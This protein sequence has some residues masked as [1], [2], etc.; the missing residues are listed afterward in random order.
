MS[1][2]QGHRT[3]DVRP[4]N[5]PPMASIFTDF[6]EHFDDAGA[7]GHMGDLAIWRVCGEPRSGWRSDFDFGYFE[8][9]EDDIT[10]I[11]E[12]TDDGGGECVGDGEPR[13]RCCPRG[14]T[15]DAAGHC[16]PWCHIEH[17][18]PRDWRLCGLGFD[19]RG[20]RCLDGSAPTNDTPFGCVAASPIL[21]AKVCPAGWART[22]TPGAGE[23]CAPTPQQRH[24]RRGEQAGPDGVCRP[25]C[26][27]VAWP[28]PPCCAPGVEVDD[29]GACCPEG[30][31]LDGHKQC[32]P[33]DSRLTPQGECCPAGVE[34]DARGACCV[35]GARLDHNRMCCAPGAVVDGEGVCCP[36]GARLDS[37][38]QCCPIDAVTDKRGRCCPVGAHVN[39]QTGNCTRP[40]PPLTPIPT[41][42]CGPNE[43]GIAGSCCGRD[44]VYS[45][46]EGRL[47]CCPHPLDAHG[48]CE[49][50]RPPPV[51]A[52]GAVPLQGGACCPAGR[53]TPEGTCA[54]DVIIPPRRCP[55]GRPPIGGKCAPAPTP[56]PTPSP[57][58]TLQPTPLPTPTPTPTRT[59]RP[60]P[61]PERTIRPTP[62]PTYRPGIIPRPT[63]TPAPTATLPPR[64]VL[65]GR[66]AP[67]R[68]LPHD[69]PP[70]FAPHRE[71]HVG[72]NPKQSY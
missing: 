28:R 50:P 7:R 4:R 14:M 72:P 44:S 11:D 35:K 9:D 15:P 16:R 69:E 32:C 62:I 37:E 43:T 52:P 57:T 13:Y 31:R 24:C 6:N 1:G 45:A 12:W 21:A 67:R 41:P 47:R 23:I 29:Y 22:T 70:R 51:C 66:E 56:A 65:P 39:P 42:A 38:K 17:A 40:P 49:R 46:G 71:D 36:A 55:D 61:K 68:F 20:P 53:V 30:A 2:L 48:R 34:I 33:A 58:R 59:L 8:F 3:P 26:K 27:W 25:L 54:D 64:Q 5:V 19:P 10:V 63:R 60:T 18:S